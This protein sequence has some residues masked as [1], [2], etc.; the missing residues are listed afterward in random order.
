M[1]CCLG[2]DGHASAQAMTDHLSSACALAEVSVEQADVGARRIEG[3]LVIVVVF[4]S[5]IRGEPIG[6]A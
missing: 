3:V 1:A 6:A 4:G 2:R 5:V